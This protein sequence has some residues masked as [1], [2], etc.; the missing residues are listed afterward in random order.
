MS[1]QWRYT[2]SARLIVHPRHIQLE[3]TRHSSFIT[4]F[5]HVLRFSRTRCSCTWWCRGSFARSAILNARCYLSK[6]CTGK[7][8][9]ILHNIRS[10]LRHIPICCVNLFCTISLCCNVFESFRQTTNHRRSPDT[11]VRKDVNHMVGMCAW[12][13][14]S[15]FSWLA[16]ALAG[17]LP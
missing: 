3:R 5:R 13:D 14:L 11:F 9:I 16:S 2:M 4:C 8:S 17:H 7:S 12:G 1:F 6:I 15:I 10:A